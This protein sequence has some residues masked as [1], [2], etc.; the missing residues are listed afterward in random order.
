MNEPFFIA[1]IILVAIIVFLFLFLRNNKDR[2][3]LEK[4][5]NEDYRKP[6]EN[7]VD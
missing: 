6:K 4:T 5:L 7:E 1:L 3:D 2:K